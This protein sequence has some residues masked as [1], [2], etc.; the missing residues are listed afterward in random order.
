[1]KS[2]TMKVSVITGITGQDGSYLAE[3]LLK[4]GYKVVG[5]VRRKSTPDLGNA[6]HLK[7]H[8]NVVFE[9]GDVTDVV[10]LVSVFSKHMPDE[11]YH[12]AAQ[13]FVGVSFT[14]PMHTCMTTGMGVLNV[15]EAARMVTPK[16]KIYNASSS[17][18]FGK[19]VETPQ[20][21]TTG[22]YPRSP[23]AVAKVFA[24]YMVQNYRE[25]HGMF[26]CSGILFNHES[27][28]RGV[29]FVTRKITKKIAE[30]MFGKSNK[31]KLGNL[32][33]RRDWGFAG[34]Y[35]KAMHMMLQTEDPEDFVIATGR[36]VSVGYFV[37]KAFS[38]VGLNWEDWV[39]TDS[40]LFRPA[41]V[42]LL[43]GDT[44]KATQVLGWRHETDLDDLIKQMVVNDIQS[45][46]NQGD[47]L[48][49]GEIP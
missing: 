45:H 1:M 37:E 40:S 4:L 24:H 42:D 19:V 32:D 5:I 21:E 9:T 7:N 20:K 16:S 2:N 39:E 8:P 33:A 28:R 49:R 15:L 31:L 41:E 26:A 10:S 27:P 48:V 17:E 12:L 38:Y 22:F 3:Y 13:S 18:M 25:S 35:V 23:Y 36:A 29:E 11:I 47:E 46:M 34:D 6:N 14:E 43:M 30:I 44:S